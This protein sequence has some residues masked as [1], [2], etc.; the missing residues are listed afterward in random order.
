MAKLLQR[1][2]SDAATRV[3][4]A[5][6]RPV[7]EMQRADTEPE[8]SGLLDNKLPQQTQQQQQQQ[9]QQTGNNGSEYR[10]MLLR[11]VKREVKQLME[12]S[13]TKKFIHEESSIITTLCASVENCI[14]YGLKRTS[15]SVFRDNLSYRLLQKIAKD[16]PAAKS[17]LDRMSAAES[18]SG[19]TGLPSLGGSSG[20]VGGKD[21]GKKPSQIVKYQWIRVALLEK[22]LINIVE[23]LVQRCKQ[24]YEADSII[25]D[26]SDGPLLA[27]LIVGPCALDFTKVK[28][29][30]H[31]YT[32]PSADELLQRHR[33]H[34]PI[35]SPNSPK[36]CR[37][38]SLKIKRHPS[39]S[40]EESLNRSA[41]AS[42]KEYVE[43]LHQNTRSLL[44]FGKNNVQSQT[45]SLTKR[46]AGYLSLHQGNSGL[47]VKWTPNALMLGGSGT[48]ATIGNGGG[49]GGGG[50]NGGGSPADFNAAAAA[51]GMTA[52][53]PA[54]APQSPS[55]MGYSP[56]AKRPVW[57]LQQQRASPPPPP[58]SS[59]MKAG[60]SSGAGTGSGSGGGGGSSDSPNS[61]A[62]TSS[63]IYDARWE[64]AITVHVED[65]V[66]IHC[67][68]S[69]T[70]GSSLVF[71]AQDGT[72]VPPLIFPP[73]GH[74][75]QFLT[76]LESG[77]LPNGSL[78]P[79]LWSHKNK[80]KVFPQ[81]KRKSILKDTFLAGLL[82]QDE[83]S[84][85]NESGAT[86]DAAE[87]TAAAAPTDLVFRIVYR[88][89]RFSFEST[90]SSASTDSA[91]LWQ[92]S[93]QQQMPQTP[94]SQQLQRRMSIRR[95]CDSMR[96]QIL[97]RA[98]Y[99]WLAHVR[100]ARTVKRH[101]ASLL[102]AGRESLGKAESYPQGLTQEILARGRRDEICQAVYWGGCRPELRKKVWPLLLGFRSWD[103]TE[104]DSK[105]Q[106]RELQ[107]RF[108]NLLS[109]WSP[110]DVIVREDAKETATA[111]REE[112]QKKLLLTSAASDVK[113]QQSLSKQQQQQ[114]QQQQ[115]RQES[116]EDRQQSSVASTVAVEIEDSEGQSRTA[117]TSTATNAGESAL[118]SS[119][120][121]FQSSSLP[122]AADLPPE[123]SSRLSTSRESL[124]SPASPASNGGVYSSELIELISMNWHRID[125]DVLRC[126]R[127]IP[128][129]TKPEN[130]DSLRNIM[131]SYVWQNIEVGYIQG[132]CDLLAPL[133]IVME[134]EWLALGSFAKLMERMIGNFPAGESAADYAEPASPMDRHMANLRALMQ[135]LDP[136]LYEHLLR[137][138]DYS[139]FYF[140]HRW[141]LLDFKR[142]FYYNDIFLLWETIWAAW[143]LISGSFNVFIALA[144]LREYRGV[145]IDNNMDFT[146]II[147]FYNEVAERHNVNKILHGARELVN[148]LIDLVENQ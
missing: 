53:V 29:L 141:F 105:R 97:S 28:M 68:S 140:F 14:L 94:Q 143:N 90:E 102:C 37:T 137:R 138:G 116:V 38:P 44:L 115:Q 72:Q 76:C 17:V 134:D 20:I 61:P 69:Q 98:F 24:F 55:A 109:D 31:F 5:R 32:D 85:T 25:A 80:G 51:A 111:A 58:P 30:D 43:L 84:D 26:P 22:L 120:S 132:F 99:G 1:V 23:Y 118:Q 47:V 52:W 9:Q 89:S 78:D 81:V 15:V 66:Y 121:G 2:V 87:P 108:E 10:E 83:D 71:V 114:Q 48:G 103:A 101:L 88:N 3:S 126:D 110:L 59:P 139:E 63:E 79:P 82:S 148:Q 125:K 46:V 129:Y 95:L 73:G 91:F 133:L 113:E 122:L 13:V 100:H 86:G 34:T 130:L 6:G 146:D 123:S 112:L 33:I 92:D 106:D 142:E 36:A 7:P 70:D 128:Y 119:D 56:Q 8:S 65:M 4:Q 107:M 131:C 16:C 45:A 12:E 144:L 35:G 117:S 40:S 104:E 60:H 50:G 11:Q 135:V 27:S 124:V 39:T 77:L 64:A 147:K 93:K 127:H 54:N 49:S 136:H 18:D 42:A 62:S 96:R 41:P 67:H 145:I 75:L 19:S 74:L 57:A 21:A